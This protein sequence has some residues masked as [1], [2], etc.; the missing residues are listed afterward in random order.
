MNKNILPIDIIFYQQTRTLE[1]ELCLVFQYLT[2]YVEI[3]Y[4]KLT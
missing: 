2:H 1:F 4:D 3:I